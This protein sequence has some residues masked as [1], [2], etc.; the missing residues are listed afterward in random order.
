M[1]ISSDQVAEVIALGLDTAMFFGR[2]RRGRDEKP[3]KLPGK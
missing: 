3:D 2:C 1:N